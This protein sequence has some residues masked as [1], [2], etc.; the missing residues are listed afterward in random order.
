FSVYK[1]SPSDSIRF[2][3]ID[4]FV[5]EYM[6]ENPDTAFVIAFDAYTNNRNTKYPKGLALLL[7]TMGASHVL[8]GNNDKGIFFYS[9]SSQ[10]TKLLK[11]DDGLASSC[12]GL[13][14]I[15]SR[16][17]NYSK[18]IEEY[19]SSLSSYERMN[20]KDGISIA[21]NNIGLNYERQ[22]QPEK[23]LDYY[24]KSL[25]RKLEIGKPLGIA[26]AKINIGNIYISLKKYDS[27]L[28]FFNEALEIQKE[29][30][31]STLEATII[32]SI[33]IIYQEQQKYDAA[34]GYFM[35][36]LVIR[37][38]IGD[39]YGAND[40][41][42]NL[43]IINNIQGKYPKAIEYALE[44]YD[45]AVEM[46]NLE[47]VKQ[48]PQTLSSSY[49]KS[50]NSN[51]ALKY[52]KIYNAYKDSVYNKENTEKSIQAELKYE[53]SKKAEKENLAR[54]KQELE[55]KEAVKRQTIIR[56]FLILGFVLL[57]I[58]AFL[59]YRNLKQKQKANN[60]LQFAY[61]QIEEKS[62]LLEEK[63]KEV[64]DSIKYAKRLQEAI[65]PNNDFIKKLF[66]ESFVF[67]KPK[68]I[69][70]GDFYWFEHWGNKKMFAAV[71]CTGHGVPGA[72][73]SIVGYNL[74]NQAINEHGLTK[75]NLILNEL[76]KGITKTLKQTFEDSAV[77][78]GM[79]ISLCSYDEKTNVL[80]YSGAF[81]SL[82]LLRDNA[83][84][85]IKADK[86]PVGLFLGEELKSFTNQEIPVKKGDIFYVF[87]DGYAD[88][89]GGP[90]GKKFKYKQLQNILLANASK[91]MDEQKNILENS[92]TSWQG[93]LEQID[94][95]LIIGV[96]F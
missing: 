48:S 40:I 68:D 4:D 35:K 75:P 27:S 94:D 2:K 1:N 92:I 78:D 73:M 82:W 84:V 43:A 69:V 29:L 39:K 88:Q 10:I 96:R 9:L 21:Y 8:R 36:A 3:A 42:N 28:K 18:A 32:N 67:Y 12:N 41:R 52:Y 53:F 64:F 65:L 13:G 51:D 44:S 5:W 19:L 62:N 71:D 56:N 63:N 7:R 46:Q 85:E 38:K 6:Y 93:N 47:L 31:N 59:I 86:Q 89:F 25:K 33:G 15:Y 55:Q 17:G 58:V 72:F 79:D 45:A 76:N 14:I 70:S 87:T 83:I 81:N 54:E 23:A 77:K 74:L 57:L 30:N 91:T 22:A 20:D 34:V 80:E 60:Q 26:Q 61:S 37:N 49:E 66:P 95:I 16:E 50:G 11:D 24:Q 90:K